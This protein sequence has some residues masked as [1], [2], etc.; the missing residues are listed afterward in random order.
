VQQ[1][2]ALFFGAQH[3]EAAGAGDS[4]LSFVILLF[5][6]TGISVW[7]SMIICV[8]ILKDGQE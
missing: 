7:V 2:E 1:T 3:E 5:F 6:S 4:F 8:F